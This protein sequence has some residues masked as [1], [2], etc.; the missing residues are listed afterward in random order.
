MKAISQS[1]VDGQ[2][3]QWCVRMQLCGLRAPS[4]PP[5]MPFHASRMPMRR[6]AARCVAA[7][8]SAQ[9]RCPL[10]LSVT[11]DRVPAH[12]DEESCAAC[13]RLQP[14]SVV[15]PHPPRPPRSGTFAALAL[16]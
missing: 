16:P 7:S 1:V 5:K 12:T 13:A 11:D 15:R 2:A 3:R 9:P 8:M 14:M 10:P 6:P 4:L